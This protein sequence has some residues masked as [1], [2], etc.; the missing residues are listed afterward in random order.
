MATQM[1]LASPHLVRMILVSPQ[2]VRE[3]ADYS[4]VMGTPADRAKAHV[5]RRMRH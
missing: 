2:K 4:G 1:I 3:I 5:I